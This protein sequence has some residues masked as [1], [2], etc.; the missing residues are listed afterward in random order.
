MLQDPAGSDVTGRGSPHNETCSIGHDAN[1][2]VEPA[3]WPFD[4]AA[5]RALQ[6]LQRSD[7]SDFDMPR[8]PADA[9]ACAGIVAARRRRFSPSGFPSDV[10][11][12][13]P[14]PLRLLR[15]R[16]AAR[17][18][19]TRQEISAREEE[20]ATPA[21]TPTRLSDLSDVPLLAM[22]AV[23]HELE[24]D[25]AI[26]LCPGC[27]C[28]SLQRV[29]VSG[30]FCG[31]CN[32]LPTPGGNEYVCALCATLVCRTCA[33]KNTAW[34]SRPEWEVAP[35]TPPALNGQSAASSQDP[36]CAS[37]VNGAA[38][39]SVE[40][41]RAQNKRLLDCLVCRRPTR[42]EKWGFRAVCC[43]AFVCSELCKRTAMT[44]HICIQELSQVSPATAG[45]SASSQ[46]HLSGAPVGLQSHVPAV[47]DAAPECDSEALVLPAIVGSSQTCLSYA[48]CLDIA[49]AT[50]AVP[51]VPEIPAILVKR[52]GTLLRDALTSHTQ[53]EL[54]NENFPSAENAGKA[55]QA[56]QLLWLLHG[57]L[58]MRVPG[59]EVVQP[60]DGSPAAVSLTSKLRKRVQLAEFGD[61]ETLVRDYLVDLEHYGVIS[62]DRS[63]RQNA[64]DMQSDESRYELAVSKSMLGNPA[65]A[66]AILDGQRRAPET[67]ATADRV[68]TLVCG[69]VGDDM[70]TRM[71]HALGK[72]RASTKHI[73][74]PPQRLYRSALAKLRRAAAPG[75]SGARNSFLQSLLSVQHGVQALASWGALWVRGL[76]CDFSIDLWTAV[77]VTPIVAGERPEEIPM[78]VNEKLRPI[79]LGEGLLKV[80]EASVFSFARRDLLQALEPHQLGAGSQ[81]GVVITAKLLQS[82][83]EAFSHPSTA[84]SEP[85]LRGL[86][87]QVDSLQLDA[88]APIDL[89]NAYGQF[90]RAPALEAAL[91]VSP[92]V[93][94]YSATE[95][96]NSF[97][98]YWV[99]LHGKWERHRTERGDWQGRRKAMFL[100]CLSLKAALS[101][102]NLRDAGITNLSIQDDT[103]L[104]GSA[105]GIV[106]LWPVL[107]ETLG[108]YGHVINN[109]KSE[110]W[111]P[112]LDAYPTEQLPECF[113]QHCALVDRAIGGIKA[114]GTFAQGAF[115]TSLGPW[116]R[117][118]SPARVRS[119]KA[120]VTLVN[121]R[122][123]V[124]NSRADHKLHAAWC[125]LVRSVCEALSYDSRMI[126]PEVLSDVEASL[127]SRIL[128]VVNLI[129]GHTLDPSVVL[130]AKLPGPLGG[131]CLRLPGSRN[132]ASYYACAASA[133]KRCVAIAEALGQA[134]PGIPEAEAACQVR[135]K[136]EECGV[137]VTSSG[138][139]CFTS[140]ASVMYSSSPWSK[141]VPAD[142]LFNAASVHVQ[143]GEQ[144]WDQGAAGTKLASR[145]QKG[146][147]ALAA[148]E[149]F[150][151]A[152]SLE[153][154]SLLTSSGP[155]VGAFWSHIPSRA[156]ERVD[157]M[158]FRAMLLQRVNCFSFPCG[159]LCAMP[160][161]N[162]FETDDVEV[163][164]AAIDP[165]GIH[166]HNCVVGASRFRKHRAL[167]MALARKL[168]HCG[169]HVDVERACPD[170]FRVL[171]GAQQDA[172]AAAET[173][174]VKE[175]ILDIVVTFPGSLRQYRVDVTVHSAYAPS[176]TTSHC[177][178]GAAASKG[179][180]AKRT[181]YGNSVLPLSFETGGRLGA[182]SLEC[183]SFL[184]QE[185]LLW[186]LGE[187][188]VRGWQ[189]ELE[190]VLM[191]QLADAALISLGRASQRFAVNLMV[192]R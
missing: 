102:C 44:N 101:R 163:C 188:G 99:K 5:S 25:D 73:K 120:C 18:A 165:K 140:A 4:A 116:Q 14:E 159:S 172:D 59:D 58:L 178:A 45:Q 126:P 146:L 33:P 161:S 181:R 86:C 57:P 134:L 148:C 39:P 48:Q 21:S 110:F 62:V 77:V 50:P 139:V 60:T 16:L 61:Y 169:A 162:R 7:E 94:A 78:V 9:S 191:W 154:T 30:L 182:G 82:W 28:E 80:T 132:L 6:H 67:Q 92:I 177:V 23:V 53:A 76:L 131:L 135:D 129:A 106:K 145:I 118:L 100:F 141:D 157:N 81:D 156:H 183:L 123:L 138:K 175:A 160:K 150:A 152:D 149:L 167:L 88:I 2:L 171:N 121:L 41:K 143:C 98:A 133:G 24:P 37:D 38:A 111:V 10:R 71:N 27:S 115:E 173:H 153:R 158:H 12:P 55:R 66:R 63:Q 83:A 113:I 8:A 42:K 168:V 170:L 151:A 3:A 36:P 103:Y 128:E 32:G 11:P 96:A 85:Q 189:R 104:V 72:V 117:R 164:G 192:G 124:A 22:D 112:A 29:N 19:Q 122:A 40:F 180:S 20:Y 35:V 136:L 17:I 174:H 176:C 105:Q 68:H 185:A 74:V 89:V 186:G 147:D 79:T 179:E 69:A 184:Q 187:T 1:P 190:T 47:M 127:A 108:E 26:P 49:T 46:L 119:E 95:W 65:V 137:L 84:I 43:N 93:A 34:V 54:N 87:A 130:R 125:I 70:R 13:T 56:S 109:S 107:L 155:G 91:E 114:L 166:V 31:V 64:E 142:M 52:Y 51:S 97:S 144:P 15:E 75:P 90:Y